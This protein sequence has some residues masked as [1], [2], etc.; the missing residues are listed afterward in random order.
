MRGLAPLVGLGLFYGYK[1]S[2][3]GLYK[4]GSKGLGYKGPAS[5]AF[6]GLWVVL[7]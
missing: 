2:F 7:S 4:K 3:E 1:G 6:G 5:S